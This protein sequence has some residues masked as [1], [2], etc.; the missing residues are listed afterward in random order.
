[1]LITAA[2][3]RRVPPVQN[4][5][6]AEFWNSDELFANWW[7]AAHRVPPFESKCAGLTP[8]IE[9]KQHRL[10]VRHRFPST[11][12]LAQRR[13]HVIRVVVIVVL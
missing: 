12:A 11:T 8:K 4:R 13:C 3:R 9:H 10:C 5:G 7:P 2:T 1:M 6:R